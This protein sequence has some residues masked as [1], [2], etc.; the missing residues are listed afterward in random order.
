MA[1]IERPERKVHVVT[2]DIGEGAAAK[3]PPVPPVEVRPVGVVGLLR[4]GAEPEVPIEIFWNGRWE[5]GVTFSSAGA[6]A[7]PDVYFTDFADRTRTNEFH[8][9]AIV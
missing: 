5:P 3:V 6:G 7:D 2:P 1:Q 4:N 8:N 9:A